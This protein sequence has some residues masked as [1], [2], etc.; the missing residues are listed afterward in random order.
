MQKDY[1]F[2]KNR[3][4]IVSSIISFFSKKRYRVVFL[5]CLIVGLIYF[6]CAICITQSDDLFV[7]HSKSVFA[8][9]N[10]D[11]YTYLLD[12][13]FHGRTNV[14]PLNQYDLSLFEN[15]WYLYWG[16][17]PILFILPFYL[18]SHLQAS[19]VLYTTIGGAANVMLFSSVMQ[20]F[21]K[22]FGLSLSLM[23]ESFLVLSFGLASPNFF[24]SVD[25]QICP[26]PTR[27]LL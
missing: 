7:S 20:A 15:K 19:D 10:F 16:P 8:P 26:T 27:F 3:N 13:F 1:F 18:L 5:C 21:K 14:T 25:G 2:I 22:Y 24:L 11:Y 4:K 6:Y 23:G 9:T 17:A 12:A